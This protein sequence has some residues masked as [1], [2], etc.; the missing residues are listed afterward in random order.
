MIQFTVHAIP[1]AQPRQRHRVVTSGGRSFAQ[2]YT[3][4]RDPVNVFKQACCDAAWQVIKQP[5]LGPVQVR[6]V[7]IFPRPASITRKRGTNPRV[8]HAKKP[9]VD[10]VY[11][12]LADALEGICW[13]NDSQICSV[14]MRKVIA[15]ADE[16]PRVEVRIDECEEP[17]LF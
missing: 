5:L 11:K 10:N 2:N 14:E 3:P 4:A 9:D 6:L 16:L 17:R 12:A 8:W 1:V 15:A 13:V 7:F